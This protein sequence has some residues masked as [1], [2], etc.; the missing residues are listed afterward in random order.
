MACRT[1]LVL[2]LLLAA[3][4]GKVPTVDFG[5]DKGTTVTELDAGAL[6]KAWHEGVR[7]FEQVV[8]VDGY[9]TMRGVF[10]KYDRDG[11]VMVCR[12]LYDACMEKGTVDLPT[13]TYADWIDSL[14]ESC[15]ATV[16]QVESCT[17]D[18]LKVL[19]SALKSIDCNTPTHM[20]DHKLRV[21]ESCRAI[22]Q[23]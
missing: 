9:C 20:L 12:A 11:D 18:M 10:R 8:D 2:V 23:T 6:R 5:P 14:S 13:R 16:G 7:A 19:D 1:V 3:A 4:C 22:E 15:E 17:N 21:P